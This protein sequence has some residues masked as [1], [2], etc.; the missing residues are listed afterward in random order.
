MRSDTGNM[1][2]KEHDQGCHDTGGEDVAYL[3]QG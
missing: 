2:K 1:P 3:A